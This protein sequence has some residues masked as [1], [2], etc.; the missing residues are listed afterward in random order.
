MFFRAWLH[1]AVVLASISVAIIAMAEREPDSSSTAKYYGVA[2]MPVAIAF[3]IY[4]LHQ[5]LRR[6]AMLMR[7]DPGPFDDR[8]GPTVLGI[9]L[10]CAIVSNAA[11]KLYTLYDW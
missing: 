6:T 5:Y 11:T 4:A 3:T 10:M 8:V 9:L 1:M 2:L 7:R